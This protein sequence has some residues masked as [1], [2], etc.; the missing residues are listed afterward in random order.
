MNSI[1]RMFSRMAWLLS[2]LMLMALLDR[3]PDPPAVSP[4]TVDARAAISWD[5][6]GDI[7]AQQ[8][9]SDLGSTFFPS[10][11]RW[12]S[13]HHIIRANHSSDSMALTGHA[14]DPSPPVLEARRKIQYWS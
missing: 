10:Q 9:N 11:A 13:V 5:C 12:I 6:G 2:A 3:V 4:H 1:S 7:R 8:H 14:S